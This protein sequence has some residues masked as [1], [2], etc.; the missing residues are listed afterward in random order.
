MTLTEWR[1]EIEGAMI[2]AGM[3]QASQEAKWLLGA[4]IN[5]DGA[6]VTL[7]PSYSPTL[8]EEKIIRDWLARRLKGEPL[9]RIKGVRE[10]WSFPFQLNAYTLD[11]RPESELIIE[12]VLKWIGPRTKEPWRLLDLGTGSG[13]LLVSLLHELKNASGIGVDIEEKALSMAQK[14]AEVNGVLPRAHFQVSNWSEKICDEFDVIVS[15]P[16]YIPLR[17]KETLEKAVLAYDPAQALFGG[18]N[19]LDCYAL[20]AK[21]IPNQLA[22]GGL[23]VLEVGVRQSCAVISLFLEQGFQHV[24]TLKDLQGIERTLAFER[25]PTS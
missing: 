23:V 13:C 18:E 6:F 12:A 2:Q 9:S 1:K 4:A 22:A 17:E 20:L 5:R 15:N 19:G 3:S 25:I 24:F 11:P 10:F 8:L 16:P 21:T 14:N 7:N